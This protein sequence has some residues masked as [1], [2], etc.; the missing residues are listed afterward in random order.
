VVQ[1]RGVV[2]LTVGYKWRGVVE[3]LERG[4][5]NYMRHSEGVIFSNATL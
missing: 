5:A 4:V 1:V 3:V 2:V